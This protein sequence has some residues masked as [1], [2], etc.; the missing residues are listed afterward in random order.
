[1][2]AGQS[3]ALPFLLK[4]AEKGAEKVG[5]NIGE[6]SWNLATQLWDKLSPKIKTTE[7]KDVFMD[8]A[9]NPADPLSQA[10]LV[11]NLRKILSENI[12]LARDLEKIIM[13]VPSNQFSQGKNITNIAA[14]VIDGQI[15]TGDK[16]VIQHG[17]YN[18]II[19]KAQVVNVGNNPNRNS[20]IRPVKIDLRLPNGKYPTFWWIERAGPAQLMLHQSNKTTKKW[21]DPP[22][23]DWNRLKQI[24][25]NE[26]NKWEAQGWEVVENDLDK[27]WN[28]ETG[29]RETLGSA[30]FASVAGL[31]WENWEIHYGAT[32]HVRRR[33]TADGFMSIGNG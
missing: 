4:V 29:F 12:I 16:K 26:I 30:I 27:V 9:T 20:E 11:Y 1:M 17:D 25:V 22:E 2:G 33:I 10:A 14:P 3:P 13:A 5:E 8:V 24:L 18:T 19:E 28:T 23:Y 31:T 21:W 15:I 6:A 7:V 32:F